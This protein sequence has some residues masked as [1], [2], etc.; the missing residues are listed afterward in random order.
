VDDPVRTVAVG[1]TIRIANG[2]EISGGR[3]SNVRLPRKLLPLLQI[4]EYLRSS[5]SDRDS[6][7]LYISSVLL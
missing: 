3:V 6:A 4:V 5:I 2:S 7:S 1:G